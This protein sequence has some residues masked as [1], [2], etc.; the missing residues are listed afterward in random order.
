MVE[1]G[2][3]ATYLPLVKGTLPEDRG[4][5]VG[6]LNL[7]LVPAH[8]PEDLVHAPGSQSGLDEVADGHGADKGGQTSNFSLLLV[9]F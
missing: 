6:H 8:S 5:V 1:K 4:S 9:G 2:S 3:F 7:A